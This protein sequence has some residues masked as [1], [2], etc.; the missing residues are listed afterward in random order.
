MHFDVL[1][2]F[3]QVVLFTEWRQPIQ[4]CLERRLMRSN[5]RQTILQSHVD[6][7][8]PGL[9]FNERWLRIEHQRVI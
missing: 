5:I 2:T 8:P 4:D 6:L 1:V 7:V 9:V 3:G